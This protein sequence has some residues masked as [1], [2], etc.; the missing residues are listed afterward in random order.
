M[1]KIWSGGASESSGPDISNIMSREDNSADQ[2][3]IQ[4]EIT[5]LIAYH[6]ELSKSGVLPTKESKNILDALLKLLNSDLQMGHK[7]EDVH[8]LVQEKVMEITPS[9]NN[10]RVF[11]SRNDQSHLDI[12]SF[13]LDSLLEIS[14]RL[15]KISVTIHGIFGN[16]SGFMPGYTH[17]R[18]AMPLAIATYFDYLASSF[19]EL[20][21]NSYS[22]Y[23]KFRQHCPLGYGSGYGSAIKVDLQSLS[24]KLGFYGYYKNPVHGASHRGLDEIDMASMENRIMVVISR[25]SQDFILFSSGEFGFLKLPDGFTTGSSL[26][27]NKRNPDFLEML[28]GYS[29]E[30]F[31]VLTSAISTLMNKGLGYHR[32]FQLSKDKIFFFTLR[33]LEILDSSNDM[34]RFVKFDSTR[35]QAMTENS[36]NATM[37]AF[38]M[39]STG[40]PWKEAYAA[41]G[42]SVRKGD[43]LKVFQPE[44]F[45][46]FQPNEV[47]ELIDKVSEAIKLRDN[48]MKKLL[49]EAK[50]FCVNH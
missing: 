19:A 22:L 26:M 49:T 13:Y 10:L 24:S 35:A 6:L 39:F 46:S 37:N 43:Y 21:E 4:Y 31:G 44:I 38:E 27:P 41:I 15:A 28:Q 18:Q 8:S 7:Y 47:Q 25:L 36:T 3:L 33:L 17:Y 29:S 32:E 11:L 40:T 42:N 2:N 14:R 16:A 23:E 30:S 48:C 45:E 1:V 9:G 5:G 20:A 12:R 34:L 50:A